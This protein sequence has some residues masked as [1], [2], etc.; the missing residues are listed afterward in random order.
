MVTYKGLPAPVICD[1]LSRE[2][3][4]ER[5]APGTEFQIG[6]IEMVANTGTYRG[7]PL[8]SLRRRRGPLR[9]SAHIPGRTWTAVVAH[10]ERR[11][12]ATI[13]RL[14]FDGRWTCGAR[15]CWCTPAGIA[16]GGPTSTSRSHP[17]LTGDAA[18]WLAEAGAALVG[19]DS[20]NIDNVATGS[21]RCTPSLLGQDIPIVEHLTGLAALPDQR[22]PLLRGP[23]EGA[24]VRHVPGPGVRHRPGGMKKGAA[25]GAVPFPA[26]SPTSSRPHVPNG[27]SRPGRYRAENR[28]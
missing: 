28:R 3:S 25:T 27:S 12:R 1:F 18:E 24:G 23:G 15:R 16:T 13:D 10:V 14:P 2:A 6:K 5:Y 17:F 20:F 4:R 21:A 11:G 22:R 19:I 8:P 9:A 26:P 7:Q